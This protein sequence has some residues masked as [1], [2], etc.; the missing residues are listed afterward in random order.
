M[1]RIS[2]ELS[3]QKQ[4]FVLGL[5]ATNAKLTIREVQEALKAQFGA[6]MNPTMVLS[7]RNGLTK[8][9]S[10]IV[11]ND[12]PEASASPVVAVEAAPE[13]VT[14]VTQTVAPEP[15]TV[16]PAGNPVIVLMD[17]VT[18]ENGNFVRDPIKVEGTET[19]TGIKGVTEL[20]K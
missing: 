12:A 9:D 4:N 18:S 20:V 1:P 3:T 2:K 15:V 16:A 5:F 8:Q 11:I 7:L 19:S 17:Q 10:P 13:P 6:T 14:P